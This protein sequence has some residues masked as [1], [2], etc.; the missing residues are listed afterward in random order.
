VVAGLD[1]ALEAYRADYKAYYDR[2][3]RDNSP[4]VRDANPIIYLIPGVGMLS[5]A[6]DKATARIAGEFYVN[7]INV[8]R[9]AAAWIAMSACRS[10][11]PST[12]NTGCW[13]K[14]NCSACPSRKAW[15]AVL[16][17]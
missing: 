15:P 10:R 13:K 2:C 16:L 9:G 17:W 14:Q 6:K 1:D 4:A 12:S 5:F 8:M 7:A 3:K 11:K